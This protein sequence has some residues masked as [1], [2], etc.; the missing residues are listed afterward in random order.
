MIDDVLDDPRRTR[1]RVLWLTFGVVLLGAAAGGAW[2]YHDRQAPDDTAD[3]ATGPAATAEVTRSSLSETETWE[4]TLG[5]GDPF[6][7]SALLDASGASGGS[8]SAGTT[9]GS[10]GTT[11]GGGADP[12]ASVVTRVTEQGA[13]VTRGTE[14]Y[15]INEEPVT[16]M[17]GDIPMYRDLA[18][19]DVGVDVEQL[20]RNLSKLGYDG[21]YGDD[22]PVD[23]EYDWYTEQ[24]VL[25]WQQD[26]GVEETGAVPA[27]AVVFIPEKGRVEAVHVTSGQAV[28]AGTPI[29]D[30]TGQ[31]QVARLEVDVADRDLFEI[32]TEVTIDLPGGDQVQ[33][34][35][36]SAAVVPAGSGG[37]DGGDQTGADAA[38][39]EIDVLLN[40][41]VDEA[42]LGSPVDVTIQIDQREDVLAV[43]VNAL[44]A[45][46]EGGHGLEVVAEDGTT[47]VVPVE[48]GLF[49]DGRVEVSGDGLEE[50]TVV[51][52][53]AR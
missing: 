29:L 38:I 22:F 44:L 24:A 25:Q 53:A 26:I 46:S 8:G 34:T 31:D 11:D 10:D 27:T 20:E 1:H 36:S 40:E 7:V 14:L 18:S 51:G 52:V 42:L 13:E 49:A 15:S 28:N 3:V 47:S 50:G 37:G 9:G 12:R 45:L 4:G 39:T 6:T 30:I 2:W 35:V 23:D 16:V 33:G 19:G 48:T 41:N 5:H 43:P 17:Y 21:G 32:G